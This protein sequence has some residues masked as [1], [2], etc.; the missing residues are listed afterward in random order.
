MSKKKMLIDGAHTE[1]VRIVLMDEDKLEEFEFESAHKEIN[2]GN[3]YVGE[4]TRV[5]PSLQAAFINYGGNR[6]GFLAFNEVH[7]SYYDLPPKEKKELLEEFN[8][9]G[10]DEETDDLTNPADDD[11]GNDKDDNNQPDSKTSAEDESD[12]KIAAG[13][14]IQEVSK[15]P[16]RRGATAKRPQRRGRKTDVSPDDTAGDAPN[17]AALA[18]ARARVE[19]DAKAAGDKL[20][21][22]E[23]EENA[24]ALALANTVTTKQVPEDGKPAKRGRKPANKS[25]GK[26]KKASADKETASDDEKGT[27]NNNADSNKGSNNGSNGGNKP[28]KRVVAVHRRYKMDDV[29]KPGQKVLVQINKEE[30][31]NKGAALTTYISM[32]GRFTVLMPNTPYAGGISRKITDGNDRKTLKRITAKLNIPAGMGLI[33]RTAG[34]GQNEEDITHDVKHLQESWDKLSKNWEKEDVGTL[35]HEDGSLIIRAMR[36][37][38]TEDVGQVVVSGKK[39]LKQAKDYVKLMMPEKAKIIKEHRASQPIFAHHGIEMELHLLDRTRV[40]LPSGGYLIINPTEALVS[41]DVNSGKATQEKNIENT[42]LNTNIEAAHELAR[43]LR[44]RDLAGLI[45]VDFIDMEDRRNDRKVE[46]AM[47]DALRKDRARSQVGGISDFGLLEMSRQRLHPSLGESNY[48]TCPHC[49]GKGVIRSP[50][51]AATIILRGLEEENICNKADRIVITVSPQVAIYMLNYK[52]DMITSLENN[53]K[54]RIVIQDDSKYV[55]P[56]HRLDLIRVSGDG[57]EKSQTV[58]RSFRDDPDDNNKKRK[59][60]RRT[61]NTDNQQQSKGS[62][63]KPADSKNNSD[64]GKDKPAK[65]RQN[66]KKA[67]D[68]KPAGK[69]EAQKDTG[70]HKAAD[71]KASKAQVNEKPDGAK[72]DGAKPDGAKSDSKKPAPKKAAPKAKPAAKKTD[73]KQADA[74]P[75]EKPVT[76]PLEV[77]TISVE[78]STAAKQNKSKKKSVLQRWWSK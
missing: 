10:D 26:G 63:R 39:P 72:P 75:A 49:G 28:R 59:R 44:L 58:E 32:P 57:S 65:G 69:R 5:E 41:V 70:S 22:E 12:A 66:S 62:G 20:T 61:K 64:S 17:E 71:R 48:N 74:K 7:P 25:A 36:D 27:A 43:Q 13:A 21:S 24:R 42:A 29:L 9:R 54:I 1:E 4:V 33:V 30:R 46:R 77:E 73:T 76:K 68:K 60:K 8:N 3:I 51:S 14:D 31:G 78:D 56:D 38:L 50:E 52:R 35:V 18:D 19:K 67:E 6:N 53:Y 37:M 45:V 16:K 11:T 40:N 2:R 34:M 23:I 47:R 15:A 55:A